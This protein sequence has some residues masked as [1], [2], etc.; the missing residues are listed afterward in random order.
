MPLL[1]FR[2]FPSVLSERRERLPVA[3]AG[4]VSFSGKSPNKEMP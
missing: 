3:P 2:F 4:D 1:R